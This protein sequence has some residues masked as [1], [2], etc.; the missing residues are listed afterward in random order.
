M[1][2]LV[3]Q[4]KLTYQLLSVLFNLNHLHDQLSC[5]SIQKKKDYEQN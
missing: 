1:D 3:S 5:Q 2:I 4:E